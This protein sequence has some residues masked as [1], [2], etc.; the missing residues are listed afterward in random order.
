MR[1]EYSK[2]NSILSKGCG[3]LSLSLFSLILFGIIIA[4]AL[5]SFLNKANKAKQSE[6]KQY[7]G[8]MNKG[9]Q[10]YFAEN[11]AFSNSVAALGLGLKTE[12]PN[13]KYSLRSTK[14]AAFN[15]AVSK[16]KTEK[17]YVSAVFL[18]PAYPNAPKDEMMTTAILCE[19]DSPGTIKPAEPTY[20]NGKVICG[21]GTTEVTK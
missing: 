18:V 9:Q 8:S 3:C 10:A 11:S 12:T 17:S 5:P 1:Q 21:Q 13:Y 14:K 15:Y 7:V 16:Q 6:A 19:A 20:Q 2:S 4:I